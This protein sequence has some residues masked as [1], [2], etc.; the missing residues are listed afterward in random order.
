MMNAKKEH[1]LIC[2]C[3]LYIIYSNRN[4]HSDMQ[5]KMTNI[6]IHNM[7]ETLIHIISQA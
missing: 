1:D 2:E 7:G 4:K 6:F 3:L 5:T